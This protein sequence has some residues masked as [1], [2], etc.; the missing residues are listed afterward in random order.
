M[1]TRDELLERLQRIERA[2]DGLS[3][4]VTNVENNVKEL[5]EEMRSIRVT[6]FGGNGRTGLVSKVQITWLAVMYAGGIITAT[7]TQLL[8]K[9]L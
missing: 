8:L 3:V 6:I 1:V 2:I 9:V 5:K 7:V 4:R